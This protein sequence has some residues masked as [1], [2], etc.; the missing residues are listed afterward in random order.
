LVC[1][2]VCPYGA[3]FVESGAVEGTV[4]RGPVVD[5]EVCVGCGVCE[6]HCPVSGEAAIQISSQGEDRF[7]EG[8]YITSEKVKARNR[9]LTGNDQR[10][11]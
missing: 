10:D 11:F 7:L 8:S 3:I 1:D 9:V 4:R 6:H 2:E 5:A